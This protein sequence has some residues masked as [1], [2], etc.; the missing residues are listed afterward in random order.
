MVKLPSRKDLA[1]RLDQLERDMLVFAAGGGAGAALARS[2]PLRAAA[3]RGALRLTPA[4]LLADLVIRQEESLAYQ[5]GEFAGRQFEGTEPTGV[6]EGLVGKQGLALPKVFKRKISKAN[7]A[8]KEGMKILK[9]GTKALTGS[10]PGVLPPRA[11]RTATVAAG[12]A[13]P[14]TPSKIGKG[15]SKAKNLARKLKKWW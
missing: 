14:G 13:N 5:A 8:V 4:A 10:V 15:K 6:R 11:F 9:G 7:K 1:D 2:A 3:G 12:M